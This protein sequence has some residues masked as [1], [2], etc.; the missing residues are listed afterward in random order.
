MEANA[1][2][3]PKGNNQWIQLPLKL[4]RKSLDEVMNHEYRK[5]MMDD[6]HSTTNMPYSTDKNADLL[7]MLTPVI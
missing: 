3:S 1:W 4:T 6:L 5:S 7:A 2:H